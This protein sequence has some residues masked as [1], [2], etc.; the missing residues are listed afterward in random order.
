NGGHVHEG[1]FRFFDQG[2][3]PVPFWTAVRPT[4]S[5]GTNEFSSITFG[6]TGAHTHSVDIGSFTSGGSSS[7]NTGGS[8]SSSTGGATS[9]NTGSAG[10]GNSHENRPPYLALY[11]IIAA[12]SLRG[13]QGIQGPPGNDGADGAVW[14]TGTGSPSSGT[15]AVG[16]LYL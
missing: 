7:S 5:A 6:S 11:F 8:S 14:H 10:S 15:G 16:D 13:E 9:G 1:R 2:T 4:D 3:G 12:G